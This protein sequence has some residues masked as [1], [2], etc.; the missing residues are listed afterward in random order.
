ML[1]EVASLFRLESDVKGITLL[2]SGHIHDT[3]CISC[4]DK[5]KFVLQRINQSVFKDVD[6]LMQNV[7]KVTEHLTS[8][9]EQIPEQ[10]TLQLVP[11]KTD[12]SFLKIEGEYWRVFE[13]K[14]KFE[15]VEVPKSPELVYRGA[16]SFGYFLTALSSLKS[17]TLTNTIP[18]FHNL[19]HRLNQFKSTLHGSDPQRS[20]SAKEQI[21]F[22]QKTANQ[23][24]ELQD[25]YEK[26]ILPKRITHNDTK[27]NNVLLS[28][29]HSGGCVIDLDTV[30]PG[31]VHYDFGDG[32]RTTAC[33]AAE[34]EADLQLVEID[35]DRYKA[36]L[37]GYLD[38]TKDLLT[39]EERTY[40]PLS[41]AYM[42]FIM[43]V[44]FLT[45]HLAGD[46]YYKTHFPEHNLQR[47][48]CQLKL[49][50]DILGR[51]KDLRR[52]KG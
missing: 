35:L 27:F 36:Y 17:E 38:A 49:T 10:E 39:K 41:G 21:S 6:G 15:T 42:A 13:F 44:R 12:S 5:R 9:F 20:D 46:V 3:H 30:M 45:D 7:V 33:L 25:R 28:T 47:A 34:D 8:Q 19:E 31:M 16:H 32:I 37:S 43:G 14:E 22:V 18:D 51:Q 26:G 2:G 48:K 50:A 11:T 23:L 52:M 1:E 24:L 29:S 40:L 4:K